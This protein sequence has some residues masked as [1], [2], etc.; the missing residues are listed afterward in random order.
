MKI[1]IQCN[2]TLRYLD[3]TRRWT[4]DLEDA[5]DFKNT[6]EATCFQLIQKMHNTR[7][8]EI[9]KEEDFLRCVVESKS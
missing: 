9:P 7:I 6:A 2:D 8:L 5:Y 3:I 4:S 1:V